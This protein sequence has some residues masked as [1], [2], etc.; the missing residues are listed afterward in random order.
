MTIVATT[1]QIPWL[2]KAL[3]AVISGKQ[4]E[5]L[6]R[7]QPWRLAPI[8]LPLGRKI[9]NSYLPGGVVGNF[10]TSGIKGRSLFI[11]KYRKAFRY[12]GE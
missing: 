2:V 1:G 10:V 4:I 9:G 5:Q 8:L 6:A 7:Y 3:K 11:P 12:N